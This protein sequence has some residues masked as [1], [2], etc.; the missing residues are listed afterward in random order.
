MTTASPALPEQGDLLRIAT[1][2]SVDDGKST[3]I[4]R[5]LYETQAV[6]ADHLAEARRASQRQGAAELNLALL[7][8]GLRAERD[9]GI[10]IDVAYRYFATP[11]RRF[12]IADTPGHAQYTRNMVTGMSTADVAVI[13]LDA[14]R[15]L[16]EQSRR[17]IVLTTLLRVP[18]MVVC[19]NKMDLVD[20]QEAAFRQIE[21]EFQAIC[22]QVGRTEAT[23][24][25]VASLHGDTIVSRS[26]QMPWYTG[27]TLLDLL[28]TLPRPQAQADG[29]LRLPVQLVLRSQTALG[30]QQRRYAGT[31]AG[32]TVQPGAAVTLLPAGLPTTI[33]T[34]ETFAGPTVIAGAGQSI[35]VTLADELDVARGDLLCA[36]SEP[37]TVAKTMDATTC[38]FS[39]TPLLPTSRYLLKHLTR[40]TPVVIQ[41]VQYRLA[42]STLTHEAAVKTLSMNDIGRVTLRTATPLCFDRYVSNRTTGSFILIDERTNETV[43]AGMIE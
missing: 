19:V 28:K 24:L 34:V 36:A 18:Y 31:I 7:T 3:L 11:E 15:G 2:G 32:G 22:Q 4:G 26:P 16:T 37:A 5:L 38:W 14:A 39:Q 30:E 35:N 12:I 13:L 40:V 20:Y 1:A 17:H 23:V 27:P 6:F 33:R 25:P 29:P 10:T 43:G 8:D 42:L 9:Q 41:D 21:A